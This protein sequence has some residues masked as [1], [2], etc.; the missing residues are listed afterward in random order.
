[1]DLKDSVGGKYTLSQIVKAID[2]EIR[3]VYWYYLDKAIQI[4]QS[5]IEVPNQQIFHF[6]IYRNRVGTFLAVI[7][8]KKDTTE[9]SVSTFVRLGSGFTGDSASRTEPMSI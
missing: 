4:F 5:N 6:Y 9:V 8:R 3:R 7:S 1:M 2:L